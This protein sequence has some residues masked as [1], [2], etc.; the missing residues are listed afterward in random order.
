MHG[1]SK[2]WHH[3]VRDAFRELAKFMISPFN[4]DGYP[5]GGYV[6]VNKEELGFLTNNE[7]PTD[8]FPRNL[9]HKENIMSTPFALTN[10]FATVDLV[11][12]DEQGNKYMTMITGN[13]LKS[14]TACF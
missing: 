9:I 11:F 3:E 13:L 7:H 14:V 12:V 1:E 6:K 5:T 4:F 8:Y 2:K 10:S